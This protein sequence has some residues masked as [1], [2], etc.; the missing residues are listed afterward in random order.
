MATSPGRISSASAPALRNEACSYVAFSRSSI[1]AP[2]VVTP[3]SR[4]CSFFVVSK[5][6]LEPSITS[7][8]SSMPAPRSYGINDAS[9]SATPPPRAVE[10]TF[11]ST[12]PRSESASPAVSCSRSDQRSP[13]SRG[14]NHSMGADPTSTC[15][16]AAFTFA[17]TGRTRRWRGYAPCGLS[18]V[19][20]QPVTNDL[21]R[22]RLENLGRGRFRSGGREPRGRAPF[23]YEPNWFGVDATRDGAQHSADLGSR[24]EVVLQHHSD[25]D[26]PCAR[27]GDAKYETLAV[28]ELYGLPAVPRGCRYRGESR[29]RARGHQAARDSRLHGRAWYTRSGQGRGG[30]K[31]VDRR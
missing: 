15:L 28:V 9:S 4:L 22:D 7:H 8:R 21:L 13:S 24:L 23:E 10:F 16:M 14:R 2:S 3:W 19:L 5:N 25:D 12:R 1:C 29:H 30:C 18:H 11:H 6:S 26:R 27:N 17:I 31:R 20:H